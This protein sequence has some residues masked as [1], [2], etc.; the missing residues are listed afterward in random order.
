VA[1]ADLAL[2]DAQRMFDIPAL[3]RDP[4]EY[5]GVTARP[6][7]G[8]GEECFARNQVAVRI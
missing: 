3:K 5:L 8:Q 1:E 4:Q 7:C 6:L 2:A